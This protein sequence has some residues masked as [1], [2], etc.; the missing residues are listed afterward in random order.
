MTFDWLTPF[1]LYFPAYAGFFLGLGVPW[2]LVLLPRDEWRNTLT[3]GGLALAL[4]PLFGTTWLFLL[5]TFGRLYLERALTGLMLIALVGATGAWL[6][7]HTPYRRDI[8]ARQSWTLTEKV[9]LGMVGLAFVVHVWITLFW[10]FVQYDTLWTFG[11]NPRV[12]LLNQSI[13]AWIGYYPQLV[14]LTYTYGQLFTGEFNDH[15]AKAAVPWFFAGTL[16][17]AYLLGARVWGKRSIGIYTLALWVFVPSAL[18][19]SGMGDLEHVMAL[20]FT[21]ALIFFILAWRSHHPRYA[22]ISGLLLA[23]ALWTKP[24]GGAFALGVALVAFAMTARL[25]IPSALRQRLR[26]PNPNTRRLW[27]FRDKWM[28]VIL[29]ALACLPIG[30]MWYIRNLYF[31]H[32]AIDFP[33]PYWNELAQRSGQELGWLWLILALATG[34]ALAHLRGGAD[35]VRRRRW[36][37]IL[38]LILFS[39]GMWPSALVLDEAWDAL[40]LWD[41]A[42]GVRGQDRPLNALEVALLLT[43]LALMAEGLWVSWQRT[44]ERAR[45]SATLIALLIAP[46]AGVWFWNYSYHSRLVLSITPALASCVAALLDAWPAP[47]LHKRAPRLTALTAGLATLPALVIAAH[48]TFDYHVLRPLHTDAEKY[49]TANPALMEVVAA[50]QAGI[51]ARP[52]RQ[53]VNVYTL[54]EERLNFFFPHLRTLWREPLVTDI[55]EMDGLTDLII[56]GSYAE[57][58][59]READAYPNPISAYMD[60]GFLYSNPFVEYRQG[61]I[62]GT[63]LTPILATD[64][65]TRRYVVYSVYTPYRQYTLDELAPPIRLADAPQWPFIGL[66][67]VEVR[68]YVEADNDS[69][70]LLPDSDGVFSLPTGQPLHLHLFWSRPLNG[71]PVPADYSIFVYLR[72]AATGDILAQRDAGLAEGRLPMTF[73]PSP[74]LFVDRRTWTLPATLPSGAVDLA[75]G[76]YDPLTL[77]R[78]PMKDGQTEIRLMGYFRL[79]G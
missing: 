35:F 61:S 12:F 8:S 73:L 13:P 22:L 78:V 31:G 21:G 47:I 72:D 15:V 10:P 52:F 2:S 18:F 30:G 5:G 54:G 14:P 43:G 3:V 56:G 76:L 23:G 67:G 50:I 71:P 7:R 25:L 74:D 55:R 53:S 28:M 16:V 9:L 77:E 39:A 46:F 41:W 51:E 79:D 58:L 37:L 1:F 75:I 69:A 42:W 49:A 11:Y 64:D 38:G 48:I 32:P 6:R 26:I 4:G 19:W 34:H 36:G 65:G 63:Y 59:W 62:L 29:T 57:F 68:R 40:S 45:S 33:A 44:T 27:I 70:Q 24:T 60:V 17:M 20:Y 66:Y